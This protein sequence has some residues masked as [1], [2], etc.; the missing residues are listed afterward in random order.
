MDELELYLLRQA[1]LFE[2]PY[3]RHP[4]Q[5][6]RFGP[7]K[8]WTYK[9]LWKLNP[10]HVEFLINKHGLIIDIAEF[11]SHSNYLNEFEKSTLDK[12]KFK[13]ET[14]ALL[15]ANDEL[16]KFNRLKKRIRSE[17]H[18]R[19]QEQLPKINSVPQFTNEYKS[20]L[21]ASLYNANKHHYSNDKLKYV[22]QLFTKLGIQF[23]YSAKTIKNFE[24]NAFNKTN[25]SI[26]DFLKAIIHYGCGE[27]YKDSF[28]KMQPVYTLYDF[29]TQ[30]ENRIDILLSIEANNR[31]EY[32]NFLENSAI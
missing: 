22:Y 17:W 20:E 32:N 2:K 9:N 18:S 23:T 13:P 30:I 21:S 29:N 6:L 11:S 16:I 7:Y 25:S 4:E 27:Y 14:L 24:T 5:K 10:S 28:K 31:I 3:F 19:L 1:N 15:K 8:N 26:L 12:Y